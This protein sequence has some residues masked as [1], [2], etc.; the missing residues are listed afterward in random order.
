MNRYK[1]KSR[2]SG[3]AHRADCFARVV[4]HSFGGKKKKKEKESRASTPATVLLLV[5]GAAVCKPLA[6]DPGAVQRAG[7]LC[8]EIFQ[9]RIPL[10]GDGE[11]LCSPS[12]LRPSG[13]DDLRRVF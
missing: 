6:R 10:L 8:A 5:E 9:L 7:S 4:S 1:E 11:V 12:E 3:P 2:G 13:G